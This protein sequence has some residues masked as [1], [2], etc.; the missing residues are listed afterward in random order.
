[1][2]KIKIKNFLNTTIRKLLFL[3]VT[4]ISSNKIFSAE[5]VLKGIYCG[6]NLY[7]NNPSFPS[8]KEFCITA[9][10]V[11]NKEISD[12]INSNTF[13]IDFNL[14]GLKN[15]DSI[16][17]KITYKDSCKPQIINPEVLLPKGGFTITSFKFDQKDNNLIWTTKDEN[18]EIP[19]IVEQFKWN[20]WIKLGEIPG[21]GNPTQNSYSFSIN[22]VSGNNIFRLKQITPRGKEIFSNELKYRPKIPEVVVT[23]EKGGEGINFS[24]IT[25]Y[26]IYDMAGK[27]LMSGKGTKANIYKLEKNKAYLLSYDNKTLKFVKK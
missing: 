15:K 2:I 23:I 1:M 6:E 4:F 24:T 13:E 3:T 18:A 5:I 8:E 7:V 16:I 17:I 27:L 9:L 26:E 11:N 22:L 25:S 20:R 12:I 21:K 10:T 14:L 19:F